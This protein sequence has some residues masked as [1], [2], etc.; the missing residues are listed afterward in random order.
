MQPAR[1]DIQIDLPDRDAHPVRPQ[2]PQSKNA[3]AI[4]DDDEVDG[5]QADGL[6]ILSML[7]MLLGLI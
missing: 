7:A 3:F 5:G 1:G 4:G 2:V 6:K